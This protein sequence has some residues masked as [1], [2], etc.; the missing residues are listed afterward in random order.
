MV[1]Y[2]YLGAC[3]TPDLARALKHS[4]PW[5]EDFEPFPGQLAELAYVCR[6]WAFRAPVDHHLW[7]GHTERHNARRQRTIPIA[8][9][10]APAPT[11]PGLPG[12]AAVYGS[13]VPY[14]E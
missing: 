1:L 4:R 2:G 6:S 7:P 14:P 5:D 11:T 8:F 13:Q 3:S 12:V 9:R 10:P